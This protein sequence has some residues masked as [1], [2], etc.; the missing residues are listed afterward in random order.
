MG[1]RARREHPIVT[2]PAVVQEALVVQ[3]F[4]T[5]LSTLPTA[6]NFLI[7]FG[8]LGPDGASPSYTFNPGFLQPADGWQEI[9]AV[10]TIGVFESTWTPPLYADSEK[11]SQ[12]Q[13]MLVWRKVEPDD[14]EF[15]TPFATTPTSR[16]GAAIF[17]VSG[18]PDRWE[19]AYQG[20]WFQD[21]DVRQSLSLSAE[22][23]IVVETSGPN[24]LA[25][26]FSGAFDDT[27]PHVLTL[28]G[29]SWDNVGHVE[30][31]TGA[32]ASMI[33]GSLLMATPG[34]AAVA[35]VAGANF[36]VGSVVIL[37]GR[38]INL[39]PFAP[40]WSSPFKISRECK[41]DII[42][43]RSANEMRR[44][45]RQTPR[46]NVE[47]LVT[48]IGSD[49]QKLHAFVHS[50]QAQHCFL[51]DPTRKVKTVADMALGASTV[52]VG[53][54]PPAW[55]AAGADVALR[56]PDRDPVIMTVLSVAGSV[57]TFDAT[58]WLDWPT[59]TIISPALAGRLK[60]DLTLIKPSNTN[61]KATIKFAVDVASE[62]GIAP[63]AATTM[64]NFREVFLFKPNWAN[65]V[66]GDYQHDY[67]TLDYGQGLTAYFD[68]VPYSK[69]MMKATFL[70]KTAAEMT[71]LEDQFVRMLGQQGEFYMPTFEPDML[72]TADIGATDRTFDVA[73]WDV[74]RAFSQDTV[75]RAV[76]VQL[77]DGTQLFARVEA[78][79][80]AVDGEAV[81]SRLVLD[82]PFGTAAPLD[83][84][85]MI[86]WMPVWRHA[87]DIFTS[88]W[89]TDNVAQTQLTLMTIEDRIPAGGEP[90]ICEIFVNGL[91]TNPYMAQFVTLSDGGL[92]ASGTSAVITSGTGDGSFHGGGS[93]VAQT[94]EAK[95]SGL[96]RAEITCG[97]SSGFDDAI[98]IV[99]P[100]SMPGAWNAG[101]G[102]GPFLGVQ[103]VVAD[104]DAH[105]GLGT[106]WG[107]RQDGEL[108]HDRFYLVGENAVAH[109]APWGDGDR[110][111]LYINV[112]AGVMWSRKNGGAYQGKDGVTAD[113][114]DTTT[115]VP[116]FAPGTPI[117][118]AAS[119][120]QFGVYHFNL[121]AE[122]FVDSGP[123]GFNAWTNTGTGQLGSFL[124]N[125]IG[126]L[127]NTTA[128]ALIVS[129]YVAGVSGPVS[130]IMW[131]E[132]D[133]DTGP[134]GVGVIFDSDG[135][136][137]APFTVLAVGAVGITGSGLGAP[138]LG[139]VVSEL[140]TTFHVVEG[141]TYYVGLFL[142]PKVGGLNDQ[143]TIVVAGNTAGMWV[144]TTATYP[145]PNP[146]FTVSSVEDVHLPIMTDLA[147][148]DVFCVWR[149]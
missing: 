88:E 66:S 63:S 147:S 98:G 140:A 11:A 116:I 16:C 108:N 38:N 65:E 32:S 1:S 19:D 128:G 62:I 57:V 10:P 73:G 132:N 101:F 144:D 114:T 39:L 52:D 50:Y 75:F 81:N 12:I 40:D 92:T 135:V 55:L 139:Q 41:T 96:W 26:S 109:W 37:L 60:S 13:P 77:R 131:A 127:Y 99:G 72:P 29:S 78:I 17:E 142:H 6:G 68:P 122:G 58:A 4:T 123:P 136:A 149:R 61:V 71:L 21:A 125:G 45:L 82:A 90:P 25:L 53:V 130:K 59:G 100:L 121:G 48:T 89:L 91:D 115:G 7:A 23:N 117:Y 105:F 107:Y 18:L 24:V 119:F 54:T 120:A 5:A 124:S 106:G 67:D 15:L 113:P 8:W 85:R 51:P 134:N 9:A 74:A 80:G 112:D 47:S 44:A 33:M 3:S 93:G 64:F 31:T 118:L 20:V 145:T 69:L 43:S 30:G 46:K 83:Q 35:T 34:A 36:T 94:K 28:G 133:N 76:M 138:Y 27:G 104:A 86:C 129:P 148:P 97:T 49:S 141:H 2:T 137:G 110:I 143:N 42:T 103:G 56:I 87:T 84:I 146:T 126:A 95:H 111:A 79:E 22:T 70:G 14:G 102:G